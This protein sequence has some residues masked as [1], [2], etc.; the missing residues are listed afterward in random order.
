MGG[1]VLKSATVL[2]M[3]WG[4]WGTA[5]WFSK[6]V[7]AAQMYGQ[8][9][10]A[11]DPLMTLIW[12]RR[13]RDQHKDPSD[14]EAFNVYVE[15]FAQTKLFQRDTT[16]QKRALWAVKP[17]SMILILIQISSTTPGRRIIRC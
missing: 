5:S 17:P 16:T 11:H 2:N 6:M 8:T 7:A 14:T 4:P 15:E 1:G 10:M 3:P 12:M 9:V 13:C